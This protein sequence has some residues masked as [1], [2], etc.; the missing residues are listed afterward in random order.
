MDVIEIKKKLH[1][2]CK[3]QIEKDIIL[4]TKA[5]EDAQFEANQHKGAMESR[6]DTFKE[7]AQARV[8][9][10]A[11]QLHEKS[12]LLATIVN[13][14][15]TNQHSQVAK[16]SVVETDKEHYFIS[17]YIFDDPLTIA[18]KEYLPISIESPLGQLLSG[19]KPGDE[20]ELMVGIIKIIS[21]F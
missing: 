4:T 3:K 20:V 2:M 1:K 15:P 17:A 7:E 9:G 6:Y 14:N 19:K 21:V 13:I 12:K 8:S 5:M 11:Q 18:G 16:G 10:F